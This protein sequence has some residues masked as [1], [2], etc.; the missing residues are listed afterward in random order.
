MV[1]VAVD[2]MG[3]DYAPNEIVKGVVQAL[4]ASEKLKVQLVGKKDILQNLLEAHPFP[5]NQLELVSAKEEIAGDDD[6]GLTIRRK[7]DASM[8]VALKQVSEG[9][10][11][12]VLSAGNTGA[13]MAGGL[14][15]LGRISG[16]SRPA[17]LTILPTFWGDG[18]AVLDVG[19]NMDAKPE[20][21]LQYAYMGKAYAEEILKKD[22]PRVGLLNVGTENNKGNEKSRKTF[23][24]FDEY[25]INFCGN[26]E[27]NQ[28]F[29]G[30]DVDV[31]VCDGFAGNVLLKTAEGISQGIFDVLKKEFTQNLKNKVG[32]MLLSGSFRNFNNKMDVSE[33]GGAPLVGVNG[34][35]IKCHGASHSRA[36]EKALLDQVCP[37]IESGV[38]QIFSKELHESGL[39]KKG[40]S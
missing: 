11:E 37:W 24:L 12:A 19:A 35:C 17:L 31:L 10:A 20:Q 22:N 36:I 4:Y 6:P 27:G 16:I 2:A 14:L 38:N 25:V 29:K 15:F 32:A 26:V 3:G 34:I 5:E 9:K 39:L 18:V 1:T 23:E 8:V 7:K 13:L 21:M 28:V 33:Y 40:L 30:T